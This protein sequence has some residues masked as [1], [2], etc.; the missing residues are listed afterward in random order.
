MFLFASSVRLSRIGLS[1]PFN[2]IL[3]YRA[4]AGKKKNKQTWSQSVITW[5]EAVILL[6]E[7]SSSYSFTSCKCNGPKDDDVKKN[8]RYIL[9]C[10]W[11]AV[12][13]SS[14]TVTACSH[15]LFLFSVAIKGNARQ[16]GCLA[17]LPSVPQVPYTY[18]YTSHHMMMIIP[19]SVHYT[20]FFSVHKFSSSSLGDSGNGSSWRRRPCSGTL[21]WAGHGN[22][23]HQS[24]R[25]RV[26][27]NRSWRIPRERER[28]REKQNTSSVTHWQM[29][30][31][32]QMNGVVTLVKKKKNSAAA[33]AAAFAPCRR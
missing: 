27:T 11:N 13:S 18:A 6:N 8:S 29:N 10:Q 1:K 21:L 23:S 3:N 19:S 28:K 15:L 5:H 7:L 14:S 22:G 16:S 25:A 24:N 20:L 33:A 30:Q 2:P 9:V 12:S 26:V 17:L 31:I 32:G 4:K